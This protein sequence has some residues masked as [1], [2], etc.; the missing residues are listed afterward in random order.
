MSSL[1]YITN[2]NN[3]DESLL[4]LTRAFREFLTADYH[5]GEYTSLITKLIPA[6][7]RRLLVSLD[8][9]RS[10][11][12]LPFHR[13]LL[14]EPGL[15]HE[16]LTRAVKEVAKDIAARE[17]LPLVQ[18]ENMYF[19]GLTGRF[20]DHHVS[21]RTLTAHFLGQTVCVEGIVARCSISRPKVTR[22]VHY[23]EAT[24]VFQ[25]KDYRDST[26]A[27]IDQPAT[28]ATYPVEDESGNPLMTEFGLSTYRD[29]QSLAI[30]E[31]PERAPPGQL[32]RSVEVLLDDDLVDRLKPGDR[33]HVIGT[34]R[35]LGSRN[36]NSASATFKTVLV[37]NH[38]RL[39][40]SKS[41]SATNAIPTTVRLTDQD[42][43]NIVSLANKKKRGVVDLL[44][45]S[46]MPSIFGHDYIKRAILLMLLG[47][48]EKNLAN[49]THIRGDINVLMVGDPSTAK[50]QVLRYVLN[51]ANLAVATTGRGS[52]GVGLTAAVTTDP[53]SGE[54]RLEAGAMVLADRGV[55]CIDE[56]DKMSDVDR[57]AI[58][59]VM[60]QQTVTIS[61]AGIHTSLNAR[62][63]VL[64]AANPIYG[65]YDETKD[66]HRNIALPDSLLSR[67]DLLFIVL[68][69]IDDVHDR[70]I[71][72]HVL[73]MHQYIPPGL[74]QGEPLRQLGGLIL[75]LD[76][77]TVDDGSAND[78]KETPIYE[79]N[80]TAKHAGVP[81]KHN[82]PE[83]P[84]DLLTAAFIKKYIFYAKSKI[85]PKLTP[86]AADKIKEAYIQLRNGDLNG[87][88]RR[89]L[90]V[91][92]RTLETLIRLSTA[93]AKARLSSRVDA[94]DVE[95]ANEL[96]RY[97]MFKEIATKTKKKKNI[98]S[99]RLRK[100]KASEA[101]A[102]RPEQVSDDEEEVEE[103]DEDEDEEEE[104]EMADSNDAG[105]TSVFVPGQA[106]NPERAEIFGQALFSYLQTK[107]GETMLLPEDVIAHA[108]KVVGESAAFSEAETEAILTQ[109]GD[110]NKIMYSDGTIYII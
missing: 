54:R 4:V 45:L 16:A 24:H 48:M 96:L 72:S 67:F 47:G 79:K 49:G 94:K 75:D 103:E 30:Q 20:G 108:N 13:G 53:D 88:V 8:V 102:E 99:K 52:S 2:S 86:Q 21:P 27:T 10:R 58:H 33:V 34:Y 43:A 81:K 110:E 37:A 80:H 62:C 87:R 5:N 106:P 29:H 35:S 90:P 32:P 84:R 83:G 61:K 101:P 82:D 18:D 59:E 97:A 71:A 3:V 7:E 39:T 68:D 77:L 40:G 105:A 78:D 69:K 89:T 98:P 57:V 19:V 28:T 76:D 17:N 109:M 23:C 6:Q 15:Y 25:Y 63:S 70:A 60:E 41:S 73:Q 38:V 42:N 66:P 31:M 14:N 91:T 55:V 26:T 107:D 92:A 85:E 74:S 12:D 11:M 36:S 95:A 104:D 44:A 93:H 46:L 56:F 51:M 9:V 64:A 22:S 1:N 65:Q 100:E 50:S